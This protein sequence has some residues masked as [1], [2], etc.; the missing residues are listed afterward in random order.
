MRH[1]ETKITQAIEWLQE[2]HGAEYAAEYGEP[3]YTNPARG[4]LFANWNNVPEGLADWLERCGYSLEWSDEWTICSNGKAW[5]TSPDSYSWEPGYILTNDGEM[6]TRED[7]HSEVIEECAMTDPGHPARCIPSWIARETLTDEGFELYSGE[8]ESGFFPGQTDKPE[9][10]ARRAFDHGAES[11]VFRKVENSQFYCRF[12]CWA[13]FELP[14]FDRFDICA[15]Y[16][17]IESDY[18]VGGILRER[19]SNQRRSQST[20]VQL[21]RMQYRPGAL[22]SLSGNAWAIYRTLQRRYGFLSSEVRA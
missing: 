11:V 7:S 8:L 20:A 15:A 14:Y 10:T 2:K 3:G 22:G 18:N 12:E 13:R 9:E 16:A 19:A 17:R 5:R 1:N 4:I 21:S 6:I